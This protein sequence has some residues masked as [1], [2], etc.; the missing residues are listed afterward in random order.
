MTRN[1]AIEKYIIP[2]IER[3]WNDETCDEIL[4]ALSQEPIIDKIRAEIEEYRNS[5]KPK[6]NSIDNAGWSACNNCIEIIDK[7][8]E[9]NEG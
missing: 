2:A 1:E 7:Y 5:W 8:K 4:E 3:T 6:G 9:E